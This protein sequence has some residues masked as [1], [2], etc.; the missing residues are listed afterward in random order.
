MDWNLGWSFGVVG[1]DFGRH[2]F[3]VFARFLLV[4]VFPVLNQVWTEP[5]ATFHFL[6]LT[7]PFFLFSQ[8]VATFDAGSFGGGGLMVWHLACLLAYVDSIDLSYR[9]FFSCISEVG[10]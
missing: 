5:K 7:R 4:Y 1:I 3:P 2:F 6:F 9:F 10:G 8:C